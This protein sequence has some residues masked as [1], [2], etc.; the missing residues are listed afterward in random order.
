DS[1]IEALMIAPGHNAADVLHRQLAPAYAAYG[2]GQSGADLADYL[3][4]AQWLSQ[5]FRP[6]AVVIVVT[7]G[8]LQNSAQAKLRG[9][10][11]R[12]HGEEVEIERGA[13]VRWRNRLSS[14]RLLCY[15]YLNLKF[16]KH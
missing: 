12:R 3:V 11:F 13:D 16:G 8:D 1:Y 2:F 4:T 10:W 7:A 6:R 15:L 14:S 9:F 5:N